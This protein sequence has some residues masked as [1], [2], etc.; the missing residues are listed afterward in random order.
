M[1]DATSGEASAASSPVTTERP[2]D[3][4]PYSPGLEGVVAA[5]TSLGLVDGANGRLLYR[6]YPI[7]QIVKGGTYAAVAELLWTGEWNTGATLHPG[8][9]SWP[10]I[11]ALRELPHDAHP[12]DALRTAV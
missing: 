3:T 1:R 6:G 10:V 7:G 12:M 5:E 11:R 2:P 9:V 4:R 8:P